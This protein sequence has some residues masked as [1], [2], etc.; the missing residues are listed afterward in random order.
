MIFLNIVLIFVLGSIIRK[1]PTAYNNVNSLTLDEPG[2]VL[3][4][5]YKAFKDK[6]PL[7]EE[8]IRQIRGQLAEAVCD[9]IECGTYAIRPVRPK[10][11]QK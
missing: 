7:Q 2:W 5:G 11:Y 8:D 1:I 6:K 4:E 9:L 10:I 3:Y